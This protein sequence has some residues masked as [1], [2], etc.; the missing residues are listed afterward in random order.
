MNDKRRL[1]IV[2]RQL[3]MAQIARREA[4]YALANALGE[5]ERSQR[6]YGRTQDLLREYERRLIDAEAASQSHSLTRNLAFVR[7][8]QSMADE[9]GQAHKDARDQAQWQMQALAK[10]ETRLEA[11]ETRESEERRALRA[12]KERRELP[13]ELTGTSSMARKLHNGGHTGEEAPR[14]G[15]R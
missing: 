4:R 2:R 3:M 7:S 13:P 1:K 9:A 5:E 11:Q 14:Q 15:R 6:V 8:L 10:A 12:Q